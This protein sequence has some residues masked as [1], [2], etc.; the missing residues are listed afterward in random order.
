MSVAYRA[1]TVRII[2]WSAVTLYS[3]LYVPVSIPCW[4][5]A[6]LS[7]YAMLCLI[8]LYMPVFINIAILT[9]L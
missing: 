9:K 3:T 6:N 8:W 4:I 7:L 2:A 1:G 5:D